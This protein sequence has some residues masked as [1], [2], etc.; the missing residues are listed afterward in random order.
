MLLK[1]EDEDLKRLA[2]EPDHRSDRWP[3]GTT[4]AYRQRLQQVHS[5][6]SERDLMAL[7][8]LRMKKLEG[9]DDG[10]WS[11]NI[12]AKYRLA[13]RFQT[14]NGERFATIIEARSQQA[15]EE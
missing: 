9:S 8:S 11:V 3:A 2:Y 15:A 5:A 1:F 12:D 4:R 14:R 13:L 7:K 10:I 6:V